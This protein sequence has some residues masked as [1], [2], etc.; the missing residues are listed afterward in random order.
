MGGSISTNMFKIF[1]VRLVSSCSIQFHT[2]HNKMD[3]LKLERKNISLK[4]MANCML[5]A[6][7]P[8]SNIWNEA[9]KYDDYIHNISP[10]IFFEDM[11]PF[12]AWIG[13]KPDVK[14]L[15]MFED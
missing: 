12:E 1:V 6:K 2:L 3:L 14:H 5:H 8:P 13:D 9:L 11:T 7:S 15:R 10:H 4:E